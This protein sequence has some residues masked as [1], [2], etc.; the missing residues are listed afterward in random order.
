M[1]RIQTVQ[2]TKD[3]GDRPH[4]YTIIKIPE[5]PEIHKDDLC[6]YYTRV[7]DIPYTVSYICDKPVRWKN[8]QHISVGRNK[9]KKGDDPMILVQ[10][11]YRII[12]EYKNV[13]LKFLEYYLK[14]GLANTIMMDYL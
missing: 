5:F 8:M 2:I 13:N 6:N 9:W 3:I 14:Y 4:T 10:K 11:R 1:K 12:D 7:G